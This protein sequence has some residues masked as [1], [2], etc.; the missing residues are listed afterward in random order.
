MAGDDLPAGHAAPPVEVF[1]TREE[2]GTYDQWVKAFTDEIIEMP[3]IRAYAY[4]EAI[5]R[6]CFPEKSYTQDVGPSIRQAVA[7]QDSLEPGILAS[8]ERDAA[9][10][11]RGEYLACA[12]AMKFVERTVVQAPDL[13]GKLTQLQMHLNDAKAGAAKAEA[14]KAGKATQQHK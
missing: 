3:F 13:V 2:W 11:L 1:T 6:Y 4:A 10:H 9:D 5:D 8:A 12:P 14:L 7:F